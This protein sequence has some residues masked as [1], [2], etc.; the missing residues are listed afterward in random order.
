MCSCL[1]TTFYL[2]TTVYSISTG[3][4]WKYARYHQ[5]PNKDARGAIKYGS[6][7]ASTD[8]FRCPEFVDLIDFTELYRFYAPGG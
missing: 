2:L 5:G 3:P 8:T 4:N 6:A 7:L 1:S